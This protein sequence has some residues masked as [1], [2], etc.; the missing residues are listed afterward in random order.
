MELIIVI[1]L[2]ALLAAITFVA[3]DPARRIGESRNSRR[4]SEALNIK[5]ALEKYTVDNITL[6][7]TITALTDNTNYMIAAVG[8]SAGGTVTCTALGAEITKVDIAD[9]VDLVPTYLPTMPVDPTESAPYT[10]GTGY[11]FSKV[12]SIIVDIK[13]CTVYTV[14]VAESTPTTITGLSFDGSAVVVDA[15]ATTYN[16]VT[17]LDS[18]NFVSAYNDTTTGGGRAAVGVVTG[19]SIA[20]GSDYQYNAGATLENSLTALSSTK[21]VVAYRDNANG[22]YGQAVVG[23]VSGTTISYGSEYPF[24]GTNVSYRPAVTALSS[25]KFVVVYQDNAS[26]DLVTKVGSVSG[27]AISYGS[28]TTVHTGGQNDVR[29]ATLDDSHFVIIFE[30]SAAGNSVAYVGTVTGTSIAFGSEYTYN[31]GLLREPNITALD[32]NTILIVYED[33]ANSSYGT[34][35]VGTISGTT[36]SF[37]SEYVYESEATRYHATSKI[38][39]S[40]AVIS[41]RKSTLDGYSRIA[42]IDGTTISFLDSVNYTANIVAYNGVGVLDSTSFVNGYADNTNSNRATA[43]VGTIAWE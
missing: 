41:Y 20:F 19:S 43:I 24:N 6:P 26:S 16:Q 38:D 31:T 34:A 14:A 13:P 23:T 8:D 9:G 11:Y 40:N 5:K 29:L 28:G 17:V 35:I 1:A 3:I 10:N 32:A 2:I 37:G 42:T 22:N 18:T 25:T 39:A 7:S 4:Y 27:N 33:S 21:F 12:G 30:D 15:G 36:I